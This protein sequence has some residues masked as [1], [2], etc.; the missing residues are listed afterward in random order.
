MTEEQWLACTTPEPL[1][2]CLDGKASDRKLRLFAVACCRRVS[3]LLVDVRSRVGVEVAERDAEGLVTHEER[4]GAAHDAGLAFVE[5]GAAADA[6]APDLAT[7][8]DWFYDRAEARW[9]WDA[10]Q[11]A[12]RAAV[13]GDPLDPDAV[14]A[15]ALAAFAAH[16]AVSLPGRLA[17]EFA[18]GHAALAVVFAAHPPAEPEAGDPGELLGQC[19]LLGDIFGHPFRPVPPALSWLTSDVVALAH[20]VYQERELPSGTLD[21]ARLAVLADA[22]EEA[23]CRDDQVLGHLRGPGPHVRG[24]FAVDLLLGKG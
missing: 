22:L 7:A 6:A 21:P 13:E 12:Y 2:G 8:L 10:Y 18:A 23:D 1:L 14:R 9:T 24:C 11:A 19:R 17:A 3:H 20:A 16:S 15:T 4:A 5:L